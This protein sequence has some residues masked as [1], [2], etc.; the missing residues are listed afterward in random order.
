ME[1]TRPARKGYRIGYSI[2][3]AGA[4]LYLAG[5]FLPFYGVGAQTSIFDDLVHPD[6]YSRSARAAVSGSM[7]LFAGMV[8]VTVTCIRGLRADDPRRAWPWLAS[9]VTAWGLTCLGWFLR[10]A[11]SAVGPRAGFWC[12]L[13]GVLVVAAGTVVAAVMSRTKTRIV[14]PRPD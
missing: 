7:F 4:A 5:C 10:Y 3:L 2:A 8:V 13:A 6:N 14:D 12:I 1:A 9:A 11:A